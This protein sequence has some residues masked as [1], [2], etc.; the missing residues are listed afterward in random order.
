METLVREKSVRRKQPSQPAALP[1]TR[2][3]SGHPADECPACH[4][5]HMCWIANEA[6]SYNYWCEAC[7]RCWTVGPKGA[8]RANPVLCTACEYRD[9]CLAGLRVEIAAC[10]WLRRN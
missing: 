5:K 2:Y 3:P 4:G 7:A 1:T 10:P 6:G 9:R 8:V